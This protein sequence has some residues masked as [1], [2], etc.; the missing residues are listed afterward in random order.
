MMTTRAIV[1]FVAVIAVGSAAR[2]SVPI[3]VET[4]AGRR[5]AMSRVADAG[6]ELKKGNIPAATRDVDEALRDDPKSWPA[7]YM[8]AQIFAS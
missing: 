3:V 2:A 6:E 5:L 8:R 1:L 7:L 4:D